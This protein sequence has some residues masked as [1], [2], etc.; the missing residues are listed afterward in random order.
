MGGTR[1]DKDIAP[2]V[3]ASTVNTLITAGKT[4]RAS[5][6][7]TTFGDTKGKRVS[8]AILENAHPKKWI[9]I[10]RAMVGSHTAWRKLRSSSASTG[11]TRGMMHSLLILHSL[12]ES[13]LGPGSHS[14]PNRLRQLVWKPSWARKTRPSRLDLTE[15]NDCLD[16]G[17]F[18]GPPGGYKVEFPDGI[19]T[20]VRFRLVGAN[21][22]GSRQLR[23]EFHISARWALADPTEHIRSGALKGA[24]HFADFSVGV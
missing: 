13:V 12:R 6:N 2:S 24:R 21:D 7:S 18:A 10:D 17:S 9:L 16:A 11:L 14:R 4:R 1:S 23:T 8:F 5:R 20:R 22:Q 19:E 15:D 3:H